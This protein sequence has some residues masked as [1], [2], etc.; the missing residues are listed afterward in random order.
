M[1]FRRRVLLVP[2]AWAACFSPSSGGSTPSPNFD[3]GLTEFDG[4]TADATEDVEPTEAA[5]DVRVEAA[6][7]PGMDATLDV[8]IEA[9][10]MPIKVVVGGASG[11]ENGVSIVYGDVTGAVVATDV[12]GSQSV[13]GASST[14]LGTVSMVTALLGTPEAP[15][16]YTVMG[17]SPGDTVYVADS[18][19]I[20]TYDQATLSLA[21][22]PTNP[23]LT[24]VAQYDVQSGACS[25]VTEAMLPVDLSLRTYAAPCVGFVATSTQ[26]S[27]VSAA[28]G[29]GAQVFEV[30]VQVP[31][32]HA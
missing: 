24:G 11:Y 27:V 25:T 3:S 21:G 2:L 28:Q 4:T 10:P 14:I 13:A 18:T 22:V 29:V 5:A 19:S 16:P 31:L 8:G 1:R 7:T 9:G 23:A 6:P 12:T 17:L 26:L 32:L 30:C 20:S 15:A